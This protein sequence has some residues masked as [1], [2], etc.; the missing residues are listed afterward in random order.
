M[1]LYGSIEGS[2]GIGRAPYELGGVSVLIIYDLVTP[3]TMALVNYLNDN[4]IRSQLVPRSTYNGTNPPPSRYT[5]VI[6]LDGTTYTTD[7]STGAQ[8]ALKNFVAAGGK[9]ITSEWDAYQVDRGRLT[10][11]TDLVLLTRVSANSGTETYVID[12]AYA[13][14]PIFNGFTGT[15]PMPFTSYNQGPITVFGAQPVTRLAW[16]QGA[17]NEAAIAIRTY[18]LGKVVHFSFA[19]GNYFAGV[20]S[21]TN[22]LRLYYNAVLW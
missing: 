12:P 20:L 21:D 19:G 4:R 14:H 9:F 13:G 22:V 1:P 15:I 5:T 7:L 6:M 18:G 16:H 10:S 3:D 17:I 11:M 8:I 2:Y